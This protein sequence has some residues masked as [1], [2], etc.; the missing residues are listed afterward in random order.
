MVSPANVSGNSGSPAS[1]LNSRRMVV[2]VHGGS[3][4][5]GWDQA[6]GAG[7]NHKN[8][9]VMSIKRLSPT[10]RRQFSS[11]QHA[12]LCTN[13]DGT[14][15]RPRPPSCG[16]LRLHGEPLASCVALYSLTVVSEPSACL[17]FGVSRQPIVRWSSSVGSSFGM[18]GDEISVNFP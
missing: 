12:R 1:S 6:E 10:G 18:N 14:L 2:L 15:S 11:V 16:A 4:R 7:S 8:G 9:K 17:P 5:T 3:I 13:Y